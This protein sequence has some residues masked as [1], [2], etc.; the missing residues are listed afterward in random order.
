M[1]SEVQR[2]LLP[3]LTWLIWAPVNLLQLLFT[4]AWSAACISLALLVWTVTR[5]RRLPLAMARRLWAPGLLLGAGARLR[6]EGNAAIDWTRPYV[7]VANHQSMI[8]VC[9][10]FRAAPVPL[11]FV[12]K[13][14]LTR[15]PFLGWYTRAMGMIGIE[16]GRS[17]AAAASIERAAALVR[18]GATL[19]TFP[20]GT[21]G[22]PGHIGSFKSGAF[23]IA[24]AAGVPVLPVAL[25]GSGDILPPRGFAVRP[26]ALIVRFGTPI[27]TSDL[28]AGDRAALAAQ[29]REQIAALAQ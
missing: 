15:L 14:E 10:L 20:E 3:S 24:I 5:S 22:R 8:D 21:R 11:R 17:R 16:R 7:L 29:A 27:A 19:A 9:A 12:L 26:G 1:R 28:K 23:Q 18:D 13:Q 25:I 4:L 2:P 6:I